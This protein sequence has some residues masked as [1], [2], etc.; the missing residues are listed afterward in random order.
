MKAP[1][2]AN[3]TERLKA[4]YQFEI[5]DTLAE[6]VFDDLTLI[7]SRICDTP[8]AL[9]SLI[10]EDRQWFKSRIGLDAQET[11]RDLAFCSHAILQHEILEVKDATQDRR[12]ADNPL[13]T[14]DP[15][16]RFYAGA[17]LLTG[18]GYGLGTLCVIDRMPRELTP[19]QREALQALSRVVLNCIQQ[20]RYLS[21]MQSTVAA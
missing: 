11:P 12:F 21:V 16:I 10:D 7:A 8:I 5:L 2:P 20:R 18:E 15:R 19:K 4:L 6:Q 9:I 14:G 3:E 1:L 13:V 17:P